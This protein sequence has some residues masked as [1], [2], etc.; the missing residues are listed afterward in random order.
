MQ[1]SPRC[2]SYQ[3]A[4]QPVATLWYLQSQQQLRSLQV[5][6]PTQRLHVKHATLLRTTCVCCVNR[7]SHPDSSWTACRQ[8]GV[9]WQ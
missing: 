5:L 4:S 3:L 2:M 1:L 8:P 9:C 7:R 6:A